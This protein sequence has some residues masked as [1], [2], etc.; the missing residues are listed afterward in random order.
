MQAG[1]ALCLLAHHERL[2]IEGR[3]FEAER[4]LLQRAAKEGWHVKAEFP[5]Q[6]VDYWPA[7]VDGLK[8]A[9]FENKLD[10]RQGLQFYL[11]LPNQYVEFETGK[12]KK[13]S[14]LWRFRPGQRVHLLVPVQKYQEVFVLPAAAV[15]R[16]GPEAYIFRQNGDVF[17]RMP[18]HVL[19]EDRQE[20]IVAD[21]DGNILEDYLIAQSG[22]AQLNWALKAQAGGE[23]GGHSHTHPH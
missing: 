10:A 8:I 6:N 13:Q 19:H 3:A 7:A 17:V 18:V 5:H 15:V 16:E 11:P 20:V 2:Q 9:F 12:E 22:A 21:D 23:E 4:P 14:R 1:Q